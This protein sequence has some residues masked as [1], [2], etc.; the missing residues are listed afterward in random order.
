VVAHFWPCFFVWI[1]NSSHRSSCVR[2]VSAFDDDWI[3]PFAK[4][5]RHQENALHFDLLVYPDFRYGNRAHLAEK[6]W[7]KFNQPKF[8]RINI[9]TKKKDEPMSTLMIAWMVSIAVF[10]INLLVLL[11]VINTKTT[12]TTQRLIQ[13]MLI[14]AVPV[15]GA[16]MALIA[17]RAHESA[18]LAQSS[19]AS[20]EAAP[21]SP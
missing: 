1:F 5:N 6:R 15:L 7:G 17:L 8:V 11:K 18:Q 20:T 2:G 21:S 12:T 13:V 10:V 4:A 19:T 16:V 3:G 9:L 14:L